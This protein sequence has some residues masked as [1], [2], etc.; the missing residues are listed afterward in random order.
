M[1]QDTKNGNSVQE[2]GRPGAHGPLP[3]E[4]P[5][6]SSNSTSDSFPVAAGT[7]LPNGTM[8]TFAA[9]RDCPCADCT[10]AIQAWKAGLQ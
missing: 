5:P 1:A 4:D 7:V 8:L 2:V 6:T 3:W 9:A 10:H